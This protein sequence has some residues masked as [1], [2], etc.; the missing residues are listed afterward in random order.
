MSIEGWV[1][2]GVSILLFAIGSILIPIFVSKRKKRK[3]RKLENEIVKSSTGV[4]IKLN[5]KY[6]SIFA[7]DSKLKSETIT[8][9]KQKSHKVEGIVELNEMKPDGQKNN[10]TYSLKGTYANK[11]LTAEYS[12]TSPT[13]DERGSINLKLVDDGV[14][15]GF[16][17]FSKI[18]T[19]NDEIRVSPYIWVAQENA[20]LLNGTFNFC[21]ICHDKKYKCCCANDRVDMPIFLNSELENI[22]NQLEDHAREKNTFSKEIGKTNL[23]QMHFTN[24]QNGSS[25]KCVFF[26][27]NTNQ[28]NIYNGRP[29][30]CR[31]FPYDIRYSLDQ[32]E[33]M[34]GYYS[35][36]CQNVPE[37]TEMKKKAHI[38]RPYFF[39]LYPYLNT[40]TSE[41]LCPKLSQKEAGWIEIAKFREFVF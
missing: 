11:I 10:Y 35:E 22:R 25:T 41:K 38:L 9:T 39:L 18:A 40:F 13:A 36:I 5:T 27:E 2:V 31:L 37:Q 6:T 21:S 15:S 33:Y 8:I 28:C 14:F 16:C 24:A 29:I 3:K 32:K 1:S 19:V 34:I 12:S 20:D 23:R 4:D 30:D 7:E 17:S 26:D